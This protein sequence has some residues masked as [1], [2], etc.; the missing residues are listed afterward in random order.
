MQSI[1]LRLKLDEILKERGISQSKLSKMIDIRQP[2][3]SDMCRNVRTEIN[4]PIIEKIA[5]ALEITDI[6]E[7]M[8]FEIVE[9]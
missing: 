2:T 3:I 1:K 4:I 9:E 6:S 8:Q 5:Q 7:L